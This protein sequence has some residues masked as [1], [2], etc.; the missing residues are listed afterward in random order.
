MQEPYEEGRARWPVGAAVALVA[1]ALNLRIAIAAVSPVLGQIQRSTGLS[2]SAAGLL[3]T[4]P[5]LCF[6]VFAFVTPRLTRRFGPDRLLAISLAGLILGIALRL[7][8]P[9]VALFGGTAVLGASIAVANVL[10]PSLV[11]RDFPNH[12][13][14]VT[15]L[16]TM[17]LSAG[18]AL[19][20]GLTVPIEHA[21]GIGWRAAVGTWGLLAAAALGIWATRLGRAPRPSGPAVAVLTMSIRPLWRDPVAVS[22]AAFMGLQSLGFYSTLSWI[23]T[24]LS[25]HGMRATEAGWLLS[26][27]TFPAVIASLLTP[28]VARRVRPSWMVVVGVVAGCAAGY[29]GLIADPVRL[30]YLWMTL[31][32]VGQ[33]AAVTLALGYISMRSPDV[34]HTG[35]LSVMAQGSGYLL[36][37]LGPLGLGAIHQV[38]GGWTIPLIVLT[39]VLGLELVAGINASRDRHI[40]G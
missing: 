34:A 6:G 13:G 8:P 21:A 33:G 15:G 18:P 38:T 29:I 7:A 5:V 20:A 23:P 27:S 11:K 30:A 19:S 25:D 1:V 2:S 24:L 37:S 10:M 40:R 4:V 22:V 31:L 36:A 28:A 35:R 9:L 26:Y 17:A 3:T 12:L 32:G 39:A 14:I 16:Y